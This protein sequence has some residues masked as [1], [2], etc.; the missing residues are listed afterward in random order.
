MLAAEDA[1]IQAAQG[2]GQGPSAMALKPT[3]SLQNGRHLNY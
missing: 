3:A 2:V 1:C